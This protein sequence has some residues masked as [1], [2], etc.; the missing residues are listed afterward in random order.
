MTV[1]ELHTL[2]KGGVFDEGV[3]E[4]KPTAASPYLFHMTLNDA[5][6]NRAYVAVDR[7]GI[8]KMI[9]ALQE[10]VSLMDAAEGDA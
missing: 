3:F 7:R 4:V 2:F 5:D 1:V 8:M 6:G 9:E 10:Q